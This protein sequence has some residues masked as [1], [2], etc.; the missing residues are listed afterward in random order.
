MESHGQAGQIQI[1]ETTK[2]LIDGKYH[3]TPM[4]IIEIKNS[5]PM[6]TYVIEKKIAK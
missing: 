6:H 5:T 4:G 3:C 1:S 2:R